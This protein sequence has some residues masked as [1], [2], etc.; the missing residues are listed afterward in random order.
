MA[1]FQGVFALTL[2]KNGARSIELLMPLIV[3]TA[4]RLGALPL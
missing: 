1:V 3:V 2:L 4:E